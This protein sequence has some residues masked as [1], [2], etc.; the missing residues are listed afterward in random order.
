MRVPVLTYHATNVSGNDYATNDHVALAHD[1]RTLDAL[2]YRIVPLDRV[3]DALLHDADLP[4]KAVALTFDDGTDF[5]YYDLPHPA[6]GEQRSLFN[7]MRDFIAEF[8]PQ[9][10]PQLHATSFVVVSPAARAEL[11]RRCLV[12]RGWYGEDWWRAATR[13]GMM[14]IANHSWDHNHPAVSETSERVAQGTFRCID[15][16]ALAD[17]EIRQARDYL[18]RVAPSRATA[19]FAYPYGDTSEYLVSEYFPLGET[20]TGTRAAFGTQPDPA[21]RG[22]NRWHLPRYV[23]GAHWRDSVGLRELLRA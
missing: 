15:E 8:G 13:S 23:C 11:D 2:G 20:V 17:F 19:L 3:V 12:G 22:A 16:R 6:H 9:Q 7:V 5:D 4:D 10:Q 14:A 1:L 21:S 18:D